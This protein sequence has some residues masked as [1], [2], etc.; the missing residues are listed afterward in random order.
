MVFRIPA[1]DLL[2]DRQMY[3]VVYWKE[4]FVDRCIVSGTLGQLD[5]GGLYFLV[6]GLFPSSWQ[7]WLYIHIMSLDTS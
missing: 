5:L 1:I 3:H 4:K 2:V 6:L 7:I